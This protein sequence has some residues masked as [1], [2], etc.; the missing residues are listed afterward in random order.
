VRVSPLYQGVAL[1]R[2][3]VLG[4]LSPVLLLHIAYLVA[5]G[6]FG[7]NVAGRRLGRMLQP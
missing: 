6:W 2:A 1:Q 3:L 4:D 7:L 5:M